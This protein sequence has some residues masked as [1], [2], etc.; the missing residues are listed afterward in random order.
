VLIE[1]HTLSFFAAAFGRWAMPLF[2]E[3]LSSVMT[4]YGGGF[5]YHL[6]MPSETPM[7]ATGLPLLLQITVPLGYNPIAIGILWAVTSGSCLFV[8]QSSILVLG[9]SYGYF[10][11]PRFA[12]GGGDSHGAPRL[13]HHFARA[14]LLARNRTRALMTINSMSHMRCHVIR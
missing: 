1:T 6:L 10:H 11:Q 3:P 14:V 13:L 2:S 4:S 5:L 12:K 8:Y 9:Y 7:I